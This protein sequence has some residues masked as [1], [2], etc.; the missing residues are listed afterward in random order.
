MAL[1]KV[2]QLADASGFELVFAGAPD[3]VQRQLQR[4]GVVASD[5]IV[6]FEPDLDRGLE[7]CEDGLLEEASLGATSPQSEGVADLP[8]H[9]MAYLERRTLSEGT[10]LIHQGD[11]PDDMFVL[12]SGRTFQVFQRR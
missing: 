12:A 10:V 7:R 6:R 3:R 4:G 8:P 11:P 1:L 2:A 5:G 9:L